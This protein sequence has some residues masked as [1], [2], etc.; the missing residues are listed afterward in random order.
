MLKKAH[1][2]HRPVRAVKGWSGR[3]YIGTELG[4]F[5]SISAKPNL[6]AW[7]PEAEFAGATLLWMNFHALQAQVPSDDSA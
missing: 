2:R 1:R 6:L 4:L 7:M 3:N 5:D